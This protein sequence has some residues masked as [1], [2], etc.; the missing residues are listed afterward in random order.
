MQLQSVLICVQ[1]ATSV[2]ALGMEPCTKLTNTPC[3][4][5]LC[6]LAA[7]CVPSA[8]VGGTTVLTCTI[9]ANLPKGETW[10]YTFPAVGSNTPGDYVANVTLVKPDD[11]PSNDKD[12]API[13]LV[14]PLPDPAILDVAVNITATPGSALVGSDFIYTVNM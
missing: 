4:P 1:E 13:S 7:A 8:G 10:E 5:R 3:L 12:D 9:E 11:N 2:W 14:T 6:H